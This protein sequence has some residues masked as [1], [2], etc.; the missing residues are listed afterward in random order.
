MSYHKAICKAKTV[1]ESFSL[2]KQ[3]NYN[4]K[5]H[6]CSK[7]TEHIS[8]LDVELIHLFHFNCKI[9]SLLEPRQKSFSQVKMHKL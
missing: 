9:C 2:N 7:L 3:T 1:L 6:A 8:H 4:K 5:K